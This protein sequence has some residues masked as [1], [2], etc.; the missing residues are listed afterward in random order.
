MQ[1]LGLRAD[2]E[3]CIC[4]ARTAQTIQDLPNYTSKKNLRPGRGTPPPHHSVAKIRCLNILRLFC[5]TEIAGKDVL[6]G[7]MGGGG[8]KKIDNS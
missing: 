2:G 8:I 7:G 5:Y 4:R 3:L 6:P 1:D